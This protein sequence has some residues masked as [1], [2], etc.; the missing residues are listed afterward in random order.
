MKSKTTVR[1]PIYLVIYLAICLAASLTACATPAVRQD[2]QTKQNLQAESTGLL[3][4]AYQ[5]NE[6]GAIEPCG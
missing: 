2:S 3:M 4:I 6:A 1:G 5:S